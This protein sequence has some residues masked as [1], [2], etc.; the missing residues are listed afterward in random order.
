MIQLDFKS[1]KD[2]QVEINVSYFK[3]ETKINDQSEDLSSMI[4]F[5]CKISSM[6]SLFV[7]DTPWVLGQMQTLSQ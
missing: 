3:L 5:H 1:S 7:R 6:Y 2:N 4:I